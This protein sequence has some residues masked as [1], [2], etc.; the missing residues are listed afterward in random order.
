MSVTKSIIIE[1]VS[2]LAKLLYHE[3]I[4]KSSPDNLPKFNNP[5]ASNI[6][7]GNDTFTFKYA[8]TQPDRL[9]FMESRRK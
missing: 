6:E 2:F 9:D 5:L 1:K 3:E 8:T 4:S 7:A